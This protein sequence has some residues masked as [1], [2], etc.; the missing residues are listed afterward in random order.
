MVEQI[1]ADQSGA[2]D[3]QS[4]S[5]LSIHDIRCVLPPTLTSILRGCFGLDRSHRQVCCRLSWTRFDILIAGNFV[6]SECKSMVR[7]F[8]KAEVGCSGWAAGSAVRGTKIW[9]RFLL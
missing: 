3:D 8:A 5:N 2:A 4:V 7:N 6:V 1:A 9:G